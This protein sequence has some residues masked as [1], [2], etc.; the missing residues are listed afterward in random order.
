M[1]ESFSIHRSWGA[2]RTPYPTATGSGGGLPSQSP[3]FASAPPRSPHLVGLGK[4]PVTPYLTGAVEIS[5]PIWRYQT[6]TSLRGALS[7]PWRLRALNGHDAVDRAH[8]PKSQGDQARHR[9]KRGLWRRAKKELN[10]HAEVDSKGKFIRKRGSVPQTEGLSEAE[11]E[12]DQEKRGVRVRGTQFRY[13]S[14]VPVSYCLK[15]FVNPFSLTRTYSEDGEGCLAGEGK[16]MR[17][18]RPG[19]G[20]SLRS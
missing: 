19:A 3:G 7:H 10:T 1:I 14:L 11:G 17:S 2:V 8:F 12:Q 9:E 20:P 6:L 4:D 18:E 16:N 15:D 5:Y 13:R